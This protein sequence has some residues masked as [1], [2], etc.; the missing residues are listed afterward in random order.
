MSD[1]IQRTSDGSSRD[2]SANH[3]RTAN[4]P[5]TPGLPSSGQPK[6]RTGLVASV[7]AAHFLHDV[8][9][10][11]LAPLLPL[12]IGKLSLSLFLAS[13]LTVFMQ[14]PSIFNPFLGVFVDRKHWQR[15]LLVLAPG[16][17]GVLLCLVGLAPDYA[18]L[19]VILLVAGCSVAAIHVAGP[20]LVHRF[21]G[22]SVGRGMSFFMVGGE[23]ARTVGPLV[24]VQAVSSF[25]LAGIWKLAPVAALSSLL[26][27]RTIPPVEVPTD[28]EPPLSLP[29]LLRRMS[30][31]FT[32]V[33]GILLARAFMVGAL[34]TFLPTY[35]Y[36]K[37]QGLW[38]AN[39]SL[40]ILELGGVVGALLSGTL[41]DHW[42]RRNVLFVAVVLSPIL[43]LLF[44]ATDGPVRLGVLA[45]LGLVTLSTTPVLMALVVESSGSSPAAATGTFM[46]I[47]FALRSLITLLVGAAGDLFGLDATYVG[48]A[49]LASLGLPF[50]FR[51]PKKSVWSAG[52]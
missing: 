31:L 28:R 46:M 32:A 17:T 26:L 5:A 15:P 2:G 6:F 40:S 39:V 35:I 49:V 10:A 3:G 1:S 52:N 21:S 36:G 23:L 45:V 12:L 18:A 22:P 25:G 11:L 42:G 7:A 43:M 41:S 24:A 9:S 4:G 38:I 51:L 30:G 50:V 44:L 29:A 8:G 16:M 48:C 33:I 47:S 13:T 37:G 19:V 20:V 27:A 34:T 14:L